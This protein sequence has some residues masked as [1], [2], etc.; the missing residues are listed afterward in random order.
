MK[1]P[2]FLERKEKLFSPKTPREELVRWGTQ[3]LEADRVHDAVAFYRQAR[4]QEGLKRIL[5][6]AIEEGDAFLYREALDGMD[7]PDADPKKW[8]RLAQQAESKGRW[9][10]ALNA[11]E[12]LE[13][14]LGCK[15]VREAIRNM[16]GGSS[17]EKAFGQG[18]EGPKQE[19]RT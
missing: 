9:Q 11:Y 14:E 13:D 3:Y 18:Q 2:S 8:A 4:H 16:M 19:D 15:R 7:P 1:W 6:Q 12:Q 17:P 10:D 5:E